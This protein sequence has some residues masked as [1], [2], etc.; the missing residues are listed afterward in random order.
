MTRQET[1]KLI[2]MIKS[3]YPKT[4]EKFTNKDFEGML[5]MWAMCLEEYDFRVIATALKAYVLTNESGF[6]PAPG[7]LIGY[8]RQSNPASDLT[9]NE[10]WSL[11]Y[12][13][14]CN[15]NYNAEAEFEKL[16][17]MCQKAIG[18]AASLRELAQMDIDTVQSVEGSHFKRNYENL[19]KRQAEYDKIPQTTREALESFRSGLMIGENERENHESACGVDDF[20]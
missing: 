7:Q 1:T 13:A 11:V 15:S 8:T 19:V 10:A 20:T 5:D 16:P 12:K 4:Y 18:S 9:S 17:L 3:A 6:P 14:I 2:F